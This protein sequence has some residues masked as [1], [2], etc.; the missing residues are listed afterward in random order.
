MRQVEE[1]RAIYDWSVMEVIKPW[2]TMLS[3]VSELKGHKQEDI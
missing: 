3:F 2:V 1:K